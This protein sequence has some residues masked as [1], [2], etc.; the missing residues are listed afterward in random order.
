MP[1]IRS[2]QAT[3]EPATV[4]APGEAQTTEENIEVVEVL[5]VVAKV[6]TLAETVA[7]TITREEASAAPTTTAEVEATIREAVAIEI[8]T[9]EIIMI[10]SNQK[11]TMVKAMMTTKKVMM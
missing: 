4:S 1:F 11:N 9:T 5:V 7:T 6:I 3:T 8:T 10:G 2:A